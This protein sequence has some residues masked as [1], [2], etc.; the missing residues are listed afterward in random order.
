MVKALF[1]RFRY[2]RQS[3]SGISFIDPELL[4]VLFSLKGVPE[5]SEDLPRRKSKIADF[6][7]H[8]WDNSP[9][10]VRMESVSPPQITYRKTLYP[11]VF[12]LH[13]IKLC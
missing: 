6:G 10:K 3:E 5:A 4:T 1:N 8:Q 11:S 2:V 13:E 12:M 9:I 7:Q